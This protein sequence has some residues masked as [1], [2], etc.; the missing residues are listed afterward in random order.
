MPAAAPFADRGRA[1]LAANAASAGARGAVACT[2]RCAAAIGAAALQRG[3]NAIDAVLAAALAETVLMPPKCGLGGE[4]AGLVLAAGDSAPRSLIALGPAAAALP[5]YVTRNGLSPTGPA[6]VAVPAAPAGYAALA[7]LGV[8]GLAAAVEPAVRLAQR[9]VIW[10]PLCARLAMQADGLLRR[11]QPEGCVYRPAAGP[12]AVGQIVR[13]PGM[14]ALLTDF[15]DRGGDLFT[16]PAGDALVARVQ[17]AGGVLTRA[18]LG[19]ARAEWGTPLSWTGAA[20]EV[21]TTPAPTYGGALLDALRASA[22]R[23][24]DADELP[25][26]VA[27]AIA[28]KPADPARPVLADGTSAVAAAD[29]D[30]NAAVIVHSNSFPQFGSG[31]VLPDY[32]LVLSNR[33]GRGFSADPGAPNAVRAGVRPAAT[34]HAWMFAPPGA[35]ALLGATS[36]GD[37]QIEWNA[38]LLR[39]FL[40]DPGAD[41]G[42]AVVTQRWERVSADTIRHEDWAGSDGQLAGSSQVL[43]RLGSDDRGTQA[44][45]DPRLGGTAIGV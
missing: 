45:A 40:L 35:P 17:A 31:L 42:S 43:V 25:R 34:L 22:D 3:G 11:W 41:L 15:L 39:A 37:H 12:L 10:S 2:A 44:A 38:Q 21:F 26:L 7:Q 16:G 24:Y 18:D 28:C 8:L 20:G 13:L 9:G 32:D 29:A 30:G 19:A 27:A 36:G 6:A 33:P 1:L 14:A 23:N 4:L 5:A